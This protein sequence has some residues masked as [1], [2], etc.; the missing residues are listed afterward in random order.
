M[1]R[2]MFGVWSSF[3][4]IHPCVPGLFLFSL[5]F[6]TSPCI[7]T[8]L[9][10]TKSCLI[11]RSIWCLA[12]KL[13]THWQNPFMLHKPNKHHQ[14]YII[15]TTNWRTVSLYRTSHKRVKF[16]S[17]QAMTCW[18]ICHMSHLFWGVNILIYYITCIH[19]PDDNNKNSCSLHS[20]E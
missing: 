13:G 12:S 5:L 1:Q 14:T 17:Q 8:R 10:P 18:H 16:W 19:V 4:Y 2:L 6:V 15:H 20:N 3:R 9:W 7:S 11:F